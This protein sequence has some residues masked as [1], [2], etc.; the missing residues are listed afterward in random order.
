M[1][2]YRA[3]KPFCWI[4]LSIF[5]TAVGA[6]AQ[7]TPSASIDRRAYVTIDR[8]AYVTNAFKGL[9]GIIYYLSGNDRFLGQLSPAERNQF[10][11]VG[12]EIVKSIWTLGNDRIA[13]SNRTFRDIDFNLYFS[14]RSADFVLNPGEPERTAKM[15][16]DV[17]FNLNAINNP[18][19]NF[20]LLDAI[21]IMF[22]EFGH[23]LKANK[24][25]AVI[26][27]LAVKIRNHMMG[28]YKEE[29]IK[30]G[31]KVVSLVLPYLSVDRTPIDYQ[32]EPILIIDR[33]GQA[34]SG[35]L[36][37]VG[38]DLSFQDVKAL[39]MAGQAFTRST[40]N[41]NFRLYHDNILIEWQFSSRK[42]FI[43]S[44]DFNYIDLYAN[45]D[46]VKAYEPVPSLTDENKIYQMITPEELAQIPRKTAEPVTLDMAKIFSQNPQSHTPTA[47]VQ[48]V[49]KIKLLEEKND[50]L[51][52]T[53]QIKSATPIQDA[54]LIAGVGESA[55][56]L[57][58]KVTSMG[59][60][61]YRLDFNLSAAARESYNLQLMGVGLNG[62]SRWDFDE[63]LKHRLR[64][65]GIQGDL[66]PSSISAWNGQAFERV[67]LVN[68]SMKT[69]EM[70]LRFEFP[71]STLPIENAKF[72]WSVTEVIYRNEEKV[73]TRLKN[74]LEVI[75][76]D[77]IK[78]YRENNKWVVEITS[79]KTSQVMPR[80]EGQNGYSIRDDLNRVLTLAEL[81]DQ[82]YRTFAVNYRRLRNL[83]TLKPKPAA[84]IIMSCEGL[85]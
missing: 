43:A 35:K 85:F 70:K 29:T 51:L 50:R 79:K 3:L 47:K 78:Q 10:T 17:W 48:W 24:D 26:D 42:F 9:H 61:V 83:F 1:T 40:L 38:M 19:T 22:H 59:A 4:L 67:Q 31:L 30:P 45:L 74:V 39:P 36:N 80:I 71:E 12:K 77:Q 81:T 72:T 56:L 68:D 32:F 7:T 14:D 62:E 75:G 16:G 66:T 11:L 65:T 5:L 46:K 54:V 21:Q 69:D 8:R 82:N 73:G 84:P 2:L 44:L 18:K 34:I 49:E 41:P 27:T 63:P 28:F 25:Q 23:T 55:P 20:G 33:E 76:R 37:V 6:M 57:A 15:D 64:G 52:F 13:V 53:T 60:D 58:G